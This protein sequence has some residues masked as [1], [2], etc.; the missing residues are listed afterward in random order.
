MSSQPSKFD[1]RVN[2]VYQIDFQEACS[3]KRVSISKR[4]IRWRFGFSN[5]DAIRQG[6]VGTDCRGE[7]HE[8]VLIWSLTSGKRHVLA[9]GQEVH[10]SQGKIT[11]GTFE[12]SWTMTGGH[13]LQIVAHA[14]PPLFHTPGFR[15]FDLLLDGCSYFDMPKIFE[16]G[17]QRALKKL[18][19][20]SVP[21]QQSHFALPPSENSPENYHVRYSRSERMPSDLSSDDDN[22]H[23]AHHR[24]R[25]PSPPR[26]AES[27]PAIV[28]QGSKEVSVKTVDNLLES[29]PSSDLL[30]SG[31]GVIDEFTPAPAVPTVSPVNQSYFN[32]HQIL[33]APGM[34]APPAMVTPTNHALLVLANEPHTYYNPGQPQ[35]PSYGQQPSLQ[36][37]QSTY[38][39]APPQQPQ[40]YQTPQYQQQQQQQQQNTFQAPQ[41]THQQP[42]QTPHNP[43]APSS[44]QTATIQSPQPMQVSPDTPVRPTLSVD[45][46]TVALEQGGVQPSPIFSMQPLDLADLEGR[47][48]PPMSEMQ[49]AMQKLVNLENIADCKETPEQIKA[50]E[51]KL[52]KGPIKSKPL[53]PAAPEW[54]G[55][56]AKLGDIQQRAPAKQ[57]PSKDIMRTHAFDPAAAQAGMMVVYGASSI[58]APQGFGA[59]AYHSYYQQQQLQHRQ[60]HHQQQLQVYAGW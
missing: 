35:A 18:N 23:A 52:N 20:G 45:T 22:D 7:E 46:S 41:Y 17:T 25:A 14:A 26:R 42:F 48:Q 33:T 5:A 43:Y 24:R 57:A 19:I 30:T 56:D 10:F 54:Q 44:C 29:G 21:H 3:G 38:Q 51:R 58:P 49:S 4:R 47:D 28:S 16:L 36:P 31:D 55:R 59:G 40:V 13:L 32:N 9:D 50:K 11:E 60:Q 27:L 6:Q 2:P 1:M 12:T 39:Y 8:I 53:P 15:Q 34:T 37:Q